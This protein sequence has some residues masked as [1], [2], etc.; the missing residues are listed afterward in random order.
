[1][2]TSCFTFIYDVYHDLILLDIHIDNGLVYLCFMSR[3]GCETPGSMGK[4]AITVRD[5]LN[6]KVC[7][8]FS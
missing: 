2:W 1:M 8:C 7:Y 4:L 5:M 6:Y 3:Y